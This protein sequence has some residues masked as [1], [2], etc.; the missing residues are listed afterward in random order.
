MNQKYKIPKTGLLAL[1]LLLLAGTLNAQSWTHVGPFKDA[2][3]ANAYASGSVTCIT[4]HPNYGISGNWTLYAGSIGGM[5]QSLDAG[6]TW[7]NISTT[8]LYYSG[9]RDIAVAPGSNLVYACTENGGEGYGSISDGVYIYNPSNSSWSTTGSFPGIP[10]G[11]SFSVSRLKIHPGNNQ[12]IYACTNA[13]LYRSVNGGT[14]WIQIATGSYK[15][16]EFIPAVGAGSYGYRVYASGT[17]IFSMSTNDGATFSNVNTVTSLINGQFD[18][19]TSGIHFLADVSA[20]VDPANNAKKIIYI[21][22]IVNNSTNFTVNYWDSFTQSSSTQ[23]GYA[24]YKY[25]FDGVSETCSLV[26]TYTTYVGGASILHTVAGDGNVVYCAGTTVI[27]YDLNNNSLYTLPGGRAGTG[28]PSVG[29]DSYVPVGSSYG[30]GNATHADIRDIK[31]IPS[32]NSVLVACDGG[33]YIDNYTTTSTPGM[34]NN[35]VN[36]RNNGLYTSQILGFSGSE[37]EPNFYATGE[38]DTEGFLYDANT[39]TSPST[40]TTAETP[41]A[42]ID[43]F[44]PQEILG[45]SSCYPSSSYE[46]SVTKGGGYSAFGNWYEPSAPNNAFVADPNTCVSH[47]FDGQSFDRNTF[48]QNPYRPNQIFYGAMNGLYQQDVTSKTFIRKSWPHWKYSWTGGGNGFFSTPIAMTFFPTDPNVVY[49]ATQGNPNSTIAQVFAYTGGTTVPFDQSWFNHSEDQW[50][51][52]TPDF[53]ALIDNTLTDAEMLSIDIRGLVCSNWSSTTLWLATGGIPRHPGFQI[54]KYQNGTWSAAASL[55]N[56]IPTNEYALAMV[57]EDFSNDG[58]YLTTNRGVYYTNATM[59]SWVPYQTGLPH[60]LSRQIEINYHENTTRAGTYG[61]GIWKS[62]LYC[63]SGSTLTVNSSP[64]ADQFYEAQNSVTV[65][66]GVTMNNSHIRVRAGQYIEIDPSPSQPVI[67]D[68]SSNNSGGYAFLFIH[69]CSTSGSSVYE[70][71]AKMD[72]PSLEPEK[73]QF[74]G[75]VIAFPN[76]FTNVFTIRREGD[77]PA[78]VEVYDMTGRMLLS[79]KGIPESEFQVDLTGYGSGIYLVKVKE[80]DKV[81][82]LRVVNR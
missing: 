48:F 50:T 80:G 39:A 81:S 44:N 51:N 19:G 76:P 35:T 41:A 9:I 43:K 58:I 16:V 42:L 38:F 45:R 60:L 54:L 68:Y 6:S 55:S 72:E 52:I 31:I 77:A 24:I 75:K 2:N 32:Q 27:K 78:E 62:S 56:G 46:T 12:Y 10:A 53:R 66:P 25:T 5:W 37:K 17:N 47:P 73:K 57:Y 82:L 67:M 21:H 74:D 79:E 14:T 18:G 4:P 36:E 40:F 26:T 11:L 3:T 70:R 71:V 29:S 15:N 34:Y 22:A 49:Y 63:P 65:A 61:Q 7:T 64:V 13:G 33:V 8:G 20:T 59:S 69:G 28:N 30:Y 23:S 1:A